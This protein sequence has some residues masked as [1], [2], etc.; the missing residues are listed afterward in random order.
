VVGMRC[1]PAELA[2]ELTRAE[3][4][5]LEYYGS[6]STLGDDTRRRDPVAADV[7]AA[8]NAGDEERAH[9]HVV[10]PS[11]QRGFNR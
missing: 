11:D 7:E 8:L 5:A 10:A 1:T 4:E 9:A 3:T 6:G 2:D